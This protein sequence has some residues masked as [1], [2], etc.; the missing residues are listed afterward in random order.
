M[1]VVQ[2]SLSGSGP[3]LKL[4]PRM[5]RLRWL[6][7]HKSIINKE[8]KVINKEWTGYAKQKTKC[9]WSLGP[10]LV[11]VELKKSLKVSRVAL[12]KMPLK[13]K[14]I[15]FELPRIES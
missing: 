8:K 13:K 11:A 7:P 2:G 9:I 14:C 1:I 5:F 6:R 4:A 12:I 15:I 10:H 3:R